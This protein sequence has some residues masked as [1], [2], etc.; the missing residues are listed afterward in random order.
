MRLAGWLFREMRGLRDRVSP[1]RSRRGRPSS[2]G[3][4]HTLQGEK[5]PCNETRARSSTVNN[6]GRISALHSWWRYHVEP[7]AL[8]DAWKAR[9]TAYIDAGGSGPKL[10]AIAQRLRYQIEAEMPTGS[11]IREGTPGDCAAFFS[12]AE[13]F[14]ELTH[15]PTTLLIEGVRGNLTA[16]RMPAPVVEREP[17]NPPF[18]EPPKRARK[19]RAAKPIEEPHPTQSAMSFADLRKEFGL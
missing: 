8:D 11:A 1:A 13:C 10:S 14:D 3:V 17:E 15:A 6:E 5:A 18:S 7:V 4:Q 16:L 2:A 9:W 19:K 12:A